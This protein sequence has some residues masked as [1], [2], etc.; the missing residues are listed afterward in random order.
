M[1][2]LPCLLTALW[3]L[4]GAANAQ[5]ILK[6]GD[7]AP[8]ASPQGRA[9]DLVAEKLKASNT[10]VEMRMFHGSQLGTLEAQVQNVKLGLQDGVME[11]VSWWQPFTRDL[12][13][14]SVPFMFKD[15]AHLE[16]WLKSPTFAHIQSDV[17]KNGAQRL[18]VPDVL[19][20]RGPYRVLLATKP[21]KTLDD[22]SRMKLRLPALA[23][24][25]RYWGT[26]GLGA[27]TVN[28]P[29]GDTYLALSQGTADAITSPFDLVVS[30]KF[31]E[32]A[33]NLM[34]THEFPAVLVMSLSER[35]WQ[36]LNEKQ[37]KA[38]MDALA[39]GGRAFNAE[40]AKSVDQWMAEFKAAGGKVQEFD[41]TPFLAKVQE[42]NKKFETEGLWRAG[43]MDSIAQ[44][45]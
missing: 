21:I 28:I 34:I 17:I 19:W 39:E 45:R 7:L 25:T 42:L 22:V 2:K 36:A 30:M 37:Q 3:L 14:T 41:R 44:L 10:G 29:W 43:L 1:R 32:V 15:E 38:I 33:P 24:M 40:L 31:V 13:V 11:D 23:M 8:A 27:N 6:I 18:L 16:R 20:W 9:M 4:A 26:T 35:R 5:T 12:G